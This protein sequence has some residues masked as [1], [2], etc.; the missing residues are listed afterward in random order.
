MTLPIV[1]INS[2]PGAGK[3]KIAEA[4]KHGLEERACVVSHTKIRYNEI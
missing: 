2:W 4:L 1:Y 3:R